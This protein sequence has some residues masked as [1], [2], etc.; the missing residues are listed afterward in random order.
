MF[1]AVG[2]GLGVA[3]CMRVASV[4]GCWGGG[5]GGGFSGVSPQLELD[6]F[7]CLDL[8][9]CS[10]LTQRSPMKKRRW[11]RRCRRTKGN[12]IVRH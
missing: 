8:L 9:F 5:G 4:L 7:L 11:R 12:V 3:F 1:P 2:I 6:R 10:A